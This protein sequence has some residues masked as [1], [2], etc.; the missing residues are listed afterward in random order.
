L[1]SAAPVNEASLLDVTELEGGLPLWYT[2]KLLHLR[3]LFF[4]A[5]V[6][7][8]HVTMDCTATMGCNASQNC[9]FHISH[10]CQSRPLSLC[11]VTWSMVRVD[12]FLHA[13]PQC[14]MHCL[15]TYLLDQ[16][17]ETF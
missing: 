7:C 2:V 8:L 15:N 11:I 3:L 17:L 13:L 10:F 12:A 9:T 4:S 5:I 14:G 16:S 1:I 6:Y